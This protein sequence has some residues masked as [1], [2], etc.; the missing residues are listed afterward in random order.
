METSRDFALGALV[1]GVGLVLVVANFQP[2]WWSI[3]T[4][5]LL[6][7]VTL[8]MAVRAAITYRQ[9]RVAAE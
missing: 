6:T 4:V 7:L 3:V 2:E 5:V 9:E 1:F 8:G